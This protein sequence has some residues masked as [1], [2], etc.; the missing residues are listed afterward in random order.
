MNI[1]K[2]I[3]SGGGDEYKE[4]IRGE[5]TECWEGG[6]KDVFKHLT[7]WREVAGNRSYHSFSLRCV[8]RGGRG[9]YA[10]L[11]TSY[12]RMRTTVENTSKVVFVFVK[13]SVYPSPSPNGLASSSTAGSL[14]LRVIIDIKRRL[15]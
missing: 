12:W 5:Y 15:L 13:R 9:L 2:K 1:K 4:K 8:Q 14:R 7:N 11:H 3:K 6:K 10:V